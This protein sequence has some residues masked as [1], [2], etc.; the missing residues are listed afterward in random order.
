MAY[1]SNGIFLTN[2][3]HGK[4]KNALVCKDPKGDPIATL[5]ICLYI[6]IVK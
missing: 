4:P 2:Y 5:P 1:I 3:V 6:L